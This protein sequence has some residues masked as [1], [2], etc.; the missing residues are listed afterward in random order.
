MIGHGTKYGKISE[1][2]RA[3]KLSQVGEFFRHVFRLLRIA[4][5]AFAHVPE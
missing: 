1:I 4:I 3:E 2:L 5:G